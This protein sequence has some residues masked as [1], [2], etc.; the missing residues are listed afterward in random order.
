MTYNAD[1]NDISIGSYTS[2][3]VSGFA[4]TTTGITISIEGFIDLMAVNS[5]ANPLSTDYF[6]G[7]TY[8]TSTEVPLM[9]S[10]RFIDSYYHPSVQSTNILSGITD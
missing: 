4:A 2:W 3:V 6:Y 1:I 9:D 8:A 7:Y 10:G 5:G